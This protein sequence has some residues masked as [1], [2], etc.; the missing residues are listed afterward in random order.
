MR[1]AVMQPYFFPYIGQFGLLNRADMW[2]VY[3]VAQYIRHGWVNRNRVLHPVSGWQYVIVPLKKHPH[4]A[5]I[6]QLEISTD[7][8]WQTSMFRQLEHYRTDAPHYSNVISFLQECL[9]GAGHNLARLNIKTFR[10]VCQRLRIATP[11]HVFSE[12]DLAVEPSYGP[13]ALALAICRAVGATEYIN[14]PGGAELYNAAEFAAQGIQLTI[15]PFMPMVYTCGRYQ[16][17]PA[18][19]IIDVMMWNSVETIK[20]HLD[21]SSQMDKSCAPAQP[22][23]N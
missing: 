17:E 1:L 6:N 11:I 21:G 15:Q 4:T 12:M 3:D 23:C 9:A 18:L 22:S 7:T 5:P 8:D 14:P 20:R 10:R 19:S 2:I 16:Y 13:Q